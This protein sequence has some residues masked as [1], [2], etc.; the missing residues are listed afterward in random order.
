[1]VFNDTTTNLGIC[2]EIDDL[3][4]SDIFSYPLSAKARRVNTA[5]ETLISKI[6]NADGT[7]QFDDENFGTNP[8][9]TGLLVEGQSAY[10]FADKFLD[11]E[12]IKILDLNGRYQPINPIDQ[13][14]LS[15]SL[16]DLLITNG[17][18]KYYDK[19]GNT[20]RLYPAPTATMVTLTAGLKVQFKRTGSLFTAD[21]TTKVP[22]IASP[23]HITIAKMAALPYCKKYKKDRVPQLQ[24]DII[25]E[26]KEMIK[27]YSLREKDKRKIMSMSGIS[28]R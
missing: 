27:F 4:D 20:I 15:Y 17:F 3:C 7:W 12:W 5:L 19:N 9:G 10:S 6:I 16:E 11:I 23:W 14:Q 13:S 24:L 25:E 18:P 8:V 26:T 22:G 2:Q 1:M 28:F 21:A